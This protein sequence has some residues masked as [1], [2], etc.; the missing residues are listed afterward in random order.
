MQQP[1][2]DIAKNFL[3]QSRRELKEGLAKGDQV[4]VRDAAEKAWNAVVQATDHAMGRHGRTPMPG[5]DAHRDRRDFLE[6]IGHPELSQRYS[7]FADRLHGDVFYGG[8]SL[9]PSRLRQLLDDVE[10]YL[11]Q[12]S[13]A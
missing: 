7:Y 1:L 3:R 2:L 12:V 6:E 8:A 13:T 9:P 4:K 5:R 10:D 11:R